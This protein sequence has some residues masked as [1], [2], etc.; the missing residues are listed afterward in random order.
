M[1]DIP[2]FPNI[3]VATEWMYEKINDPCVDNERFAYCDDPESLG[4]YDEQEHNGCCGF[5][6]AD[7]TILGR[8]ARIGCNYGH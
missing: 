2:D 6:D 7:I 8:A 3:E 4:T 1:A 5:F